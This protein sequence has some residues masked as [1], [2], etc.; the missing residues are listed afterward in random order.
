MAQGVI[1]YK[2]I[3]EILL[4]SSTRITF[5]LTKMAPIAIIIN[6]DKIFF[7]SIKPINAIPPT[8]HFRSGALPVHIH[9]VQENAVHTLLSTLSGIS[10]GQS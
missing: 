4:L 7:A 1:R 2:D 10:D 6:N 3:M 5:V 8:S 9:K